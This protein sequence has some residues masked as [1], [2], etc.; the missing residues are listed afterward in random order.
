MKNCYRHL[1]CKRGTSSSAENLATGKKSCHSCFSANLKVSNRFF[2]SISTVIPNSCFDSIAR[3]G[4]VFCL[5]FL[6]K[7]V[8]VN[9]ILSSPLLTLLQGRKRNSSFHVFIVKWYFPRVLAWSKGP[10]TTLSF[11]VQSL[12]N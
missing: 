6:R 3:V 12:V 2:L 4:A 7:K 8:L 1:F 5:D 9:Q 10:T 11:Y